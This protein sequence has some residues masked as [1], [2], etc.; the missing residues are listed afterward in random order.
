VGAGVQFTASVSGGVGPQ[1]YKW[2]LYDGSSWLLMSNW[3]TSNQFNWVPQAPN[4]Q[5]RIGVW[6][7]SANNTA[8]MYENANS[9][10]SISF[11]VN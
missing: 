3:T 4:S 11:P 1:Q 9:N 2:F 8:D 5:Y 6:V 10:G 7:R